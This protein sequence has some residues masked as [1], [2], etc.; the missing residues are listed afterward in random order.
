MTVTEA[1][2]LVCTDRQKMLNFAFGPTSERKW[3]LFAVACCRQ[4]WGLLADERCRHA[5]EVAERFADGKAS[6]NEAAMAAS[7]AERSYNELRPQRTLTDLPITAQIRAYWQAPAIE[8]AVSSAIYAVLSL[9]EWQRIRMP[10]GRDLE[11][12]EIIA[13]A[14]VE[15]VEP[16]GDR[17]ARKREQKGQ[18]DLLRCLLGNP[19]RP[20]SPLLPV[21][22]AWND[23][24]VV[25]LAQAAYQER[26]LPEG[27]LDN[28]RLAVLA[29]ALEEAGCTDAEILGHLRGSGPHVRGCWP[30]DLCLGKS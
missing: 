1:K 25:R 27:T 19:F 11:P 30:V 14:V 2:W 18:C 10:K 17:R 20:S 23:T 24:A 3:R 26:H 6:R 21:V 7:D 22:L 4:V 28:G 13:E 16:D 9:T 12:H 5:V 29:D 15:A 8:R